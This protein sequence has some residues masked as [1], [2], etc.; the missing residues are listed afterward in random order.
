MEVA[1]IMHRDVVTVRPEE[2][3]S[4]AARVMSEH[5]VSSLVVV[6]GDHGAA[7]IITDRDLVAVVAEGLDPGEVRVEDRMRRDPATVAP[8]TDLREAARLMAEH[9]VRHLPVVERKRVVGIVSIREL[10]RWAVEELTGGHEKPDLERSS[11]ALT[12]AVEV[13]RGHA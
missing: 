11:A 10:T 7:G 12:A 5:S 6:H 1:D 8:R 2:T 4:G 9:R 13:E 3:F